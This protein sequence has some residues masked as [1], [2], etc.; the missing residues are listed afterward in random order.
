MNIVI[1]ICGLCYSIPV[2]F[3]ICKSREE[4]SGNYSCIQIRPCVLKSQIIK[5][6]RFKRI[7]NHGI[8][9]IFSQ[10]CHASV[11]SS[12]VELKLHSSCCRI[13]AY[14]TCILC[15]IWPGSSL[16]SSATFGS[17]PLSH[18][19]HGPISIALPRQGNKFAALSNC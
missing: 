11:K 9:K 15:S 19:S 2:C 7:Q 12:Q 5:T 10:S 8:L 13:L 18:N 17:Q 14:F 16:G 1:Y 4:I 3:A 6:F